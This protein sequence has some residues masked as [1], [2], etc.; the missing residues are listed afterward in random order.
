MFGGAVL[1]VIVDLAVSYAIFFVYQT[2]IDRPLITT[3][4]L[5]SLLLKAV[6]QSDRPYNGFPSLHTSLSTM[7]VL[8]WRRAGFRASGVIAV[9]AGLI[10]ASTVLVKQHYFLDI[11]GG[12]AAGVFAYVAAVSIH[13]FS[14]AD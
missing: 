7:V 1:A 2:H 10:V 13:P 6:Y 8:L 14:P 11:V 3:T 4:D 9:W 5:P 12:I